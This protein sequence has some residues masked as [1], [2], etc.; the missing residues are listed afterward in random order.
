M[1]SHNLKMALRNLAKYR[2]QSIIGVLSVALGMVF[3]SLTYIWIRYEHSFDRFHR[4]AD[5]IYLVMGR[6]SN[7][8][9]NEFRPYTSYPEG[10]YLAGKYPQIEECFPNFLAY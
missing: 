6:N 5:D 2:L 9:D 8:A 1:F 4:D 3:C 7:T 10:D